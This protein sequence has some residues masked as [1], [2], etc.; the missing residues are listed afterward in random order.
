MQVL[1]VSEFIDVHNSL[2]STMPPC[3]KRGSLVRFFRCGS[4]D[5]ALR[6]ISQEALNEGAIRRVR[7]WVKFH[8]TVEDTQVEWVRVVDGKQTVSPGLYERILLFER[9][10]ASFLMIRKACNAILALRKGAGT[11]H[12]FVNAVRACALGR[13]LLKDEQI[14]VLKM[15]AQ[16]SLHFNWQHSILDGTFQE[17][18]A[19]GANALAA[20]YFRERLFE[21]SLMQIIAPFVTCLDL[22]SSCLNDL[23]PTPHRSLRLPCVKKITIGAFRPDQD[24]SK[25]PFLALCT[26]IDYEARSDHQEIE[27]VVV[28]AIEEP[29]KRA[30]RGSFP[31]SLFEERAVFEDVALM[32]QDI[33]TA[34]RAEP[35]A[36]VRAL[37]ET[38]ADDRLRSP[39]AT[40]AEEPLVERGEA[41]PLE[42]TPFVAFPPIRMNTFRLYLARL[43]RS[44]GYFKL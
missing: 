39:S 21:E 8:T 40:A 44:M 9:S 26:L 34:H 12:S 38:D 33:V 42:V 19:E 32:L 28:E 1:T 5:H 16:I 17:L 31:N 27:F 7:H 3:T 43:G 10:K 15:S 41:R 35:P 11:A 6:P 24:P 36:F 14:E 23:L 25:D 13:G 20:D 18:L 30:I 29:L 4:L 22:S 37:L 2:A